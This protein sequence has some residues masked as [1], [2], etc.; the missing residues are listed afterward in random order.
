MAEY[1]DPVL[2]GRFLGSTSV[3]VATGIL[4]SHVLSATLTWKMTA[5]VCSLIPLASLVIVMLSPESPS[6]LASKGRTEEARKTFFWLRGEGVRQQKEFEEILESANRT[7]NE[8]KKSW[9]ETAKIFRQKEFYQPTIVAMSI[10]L[11]FE[12]GGSHVVPSYGNLILQQ[13][14][15]KEDAHEVRWHLTAIDSLRLISNFIGIFLLKYLKR[16]T[17]IF[18]SG[19]STI[20][21]LS[22]M[23]FFIYFRRVN[24]IP[25]DLL[26]AL[27][28]T[29]ISLY[30]LSFNLGILPIVWVIVGEVFPLAY[31]GLGSTAAA[32]VLTPSSIIA[33][34]TAPLLFASVGIEG[35]FL[36]YSAVCALCLGIMFPLL[37]ETKDKT[38]QEIED[39]FLGKKV[40]DPEVRVELIGGS[41]K[42]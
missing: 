34:K 6:W 1:T 28:L 9:F 5:L 18:T 8:Q 31:R 24:M 13:L 33:L 12:F 35:A 32:S 30:V 39:S 11:I 40:S 19:I 4:L 17:I 20:F 2:R 14:L 25:S 36:V 23:S 41:V 26:E 16:R 3:F 21:F 22:S 42:S 38:L 29:L 37:P 10:Y 27:P 7:M 15:N